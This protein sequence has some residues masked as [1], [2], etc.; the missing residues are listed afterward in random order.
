MSGLDGSCWLTFGRQGKRTVDSARLA[1]AGQVLKSSWPWCG[2][3]A[4]CLDFTVV[5]VSGSI[6][7]QSSIVGTIRE[8]TCR[9]HVLGGVRWSAEAGLLGHVAGRVRFP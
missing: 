9:L 8:S 6:S 1:V 3:V 2:R 5:S 4:L 7:G